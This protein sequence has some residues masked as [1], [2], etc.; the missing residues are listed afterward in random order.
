MTL[1]AGAPALGRRALLAGLLAGCATPAIVLQP[2]PAETNIAVV[3]RGWH[4]DLCLAR[5][6]IHPPLSTLAHDLPAAQFLSF[7]FGERQ[8]LL[9]ADPGVGEMLSALLPSRSA[10][11]MTALR[12]TPEEAFGAANVVRLGVSRVAAANVAGFIWESLELSPQG[13]PIRLRDGPY[14]GSV[15]YAGSGTYDALTTCN[16]WTEQGLRRAGLP[17]NGR[18]L[19]ASSVMAQARRVAAAQEGTLVCSAQR[20]C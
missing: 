18:D 17:F 4:T 19:F 14:P 3:G 6:D 13:T 7:G 8:Y 11:L 9:S 1:R 5:D 10:L 16:T 20:P 15:F 2:G 12:T